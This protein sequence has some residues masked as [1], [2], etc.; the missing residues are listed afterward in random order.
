MYTLVILP[1]RWIL[2]AQL[3]LRLYLERKW[4]FNHDLLLLVILLDAKKE[5]TYYSM[6][7]VNNLF[8]Y[9]MLIITN[10]HTHKAKIKS[11]VAMR[12][13]AINCHP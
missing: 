8:T 12:N 4:I 11:L 5:R 3:L 6:S 13:T 10:T 1:A 7:M 2:Q 9:S